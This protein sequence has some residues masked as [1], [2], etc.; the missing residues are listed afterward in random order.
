MNN[1]TRQRLALP[2]GL[3]RIEAS[4][5]M[6][7]YQSKA[8][9]ITHASQVSCAL[10]CALPEFDALAY[11][12]VIGLEQGCACN[13]E[14]LQ[15]LI[16]FY[17]EAG[18]KRFMIQLPPQRVDELVACTL[19]EE[20]FVHYN[21]WSKLVRNTEPLQ[22]QTNPELSIKK[23][24]KEQAPIFGEVIYDCFDWEHNELPG[25]L[26]SPVGHKGYTHYAVY[27][28]NQVI[29]VGA[30]FIEGKGA[31][32][33]FAATLPEY[34]GLGA[35]TLLFKARIEEARNKGVEWICAETGQHFPDRPVKSYE[36]MIRSGFELAYQRQNW[37]YTF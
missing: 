18:C 8:R 31:A 1:M 17:R 29:A 9:M 2:D 5:W 25:L 35:Q 12:R 32:M 4:Y 37:L 15:Q 11:N 21:N 24:E 6:A 19:E 34:R 16:H 20:G 27:Y 26:S 36:N 3:E 33:A 23:I 7:Y 14:V 22:V 28:Q 30:L 13:A 10:A